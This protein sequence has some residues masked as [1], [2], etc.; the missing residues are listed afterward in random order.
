[1]R[2]WIVGDSEAFVDIQNLPLGQRL[3]ALSALNVLLSD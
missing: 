2:E 3:S 1:V